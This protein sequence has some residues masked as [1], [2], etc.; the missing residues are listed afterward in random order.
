M[1]RAALTEMDWMPSNWLKI[2][3]K[4]YYKGKIL[5]NSNRDSTLLF[6]QPYSLIYSSIVGVRNHI[7]RIQIKKVIKGFFLQTLHFPYSVN[8]SREPLQTLI[9]LSE[10]HFTKPKDYLHNH[11]IASQ[12]PN[13]SDE[14]RGV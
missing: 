11:F 4:D 8:A 10:D 14:V 12:H 7:Y 5:R 2:R 1:N 3:H 13:A 9:I 6:H